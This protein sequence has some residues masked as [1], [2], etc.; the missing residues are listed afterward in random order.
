MPHFTD[1]TLIYQ[2]GA[3]RAH[4]SAGGYYPACPGGQM[5][6]VKHW[7]GTGSQ[8]EYDTAADLPLCVDCR[9]IR[10]TRPPVQCAARAV[11]RIVQPWPCCQHCY[12]P[13][14]TLHNTH[15]YPCRACRADMARHLHRGRAII[16]S[17]GPPETPG[18]TRTRVPGLTPDPPGKWI[19]EGW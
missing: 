8:A 3:I 5:M 14:G 11:P 10:A 15:L 7:Y 4:L 1:W 9:D 18:F 2:S 12:H 16:T 13:G 17:E 19:P 6:R